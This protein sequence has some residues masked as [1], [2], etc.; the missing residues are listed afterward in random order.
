MLFRY[1]GQF[2]FNDGV[3]RS[4]DSFDWAE[5]ELNNGYTGEIDFTFGGDMEEAM[6]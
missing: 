4:S 3:D 6:K 2:V 5:N 1:G